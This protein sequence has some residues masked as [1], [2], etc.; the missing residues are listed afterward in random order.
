MIYYKNQIRLMIESQ[1]DMRCNKRR[2]WRHMTL[3][4][5]A[6]IAYKVVE[7]VLATR[8][9]IEEMLEIRNVVKKTLISQDVMEEVPAT[10]DAGREDASSTRVAK[11]N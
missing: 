3:W 7:E 5:E 1:H 8:D 10:C 2:Y 11:R 9:A 6:F 4:E